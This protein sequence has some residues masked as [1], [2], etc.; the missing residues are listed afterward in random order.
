MDQTVTKSGKV[1]WTLQIVLALLFLFA[2]G[3]KLVMSAT[4][5][6]AQAPLPALFLRFIGVCELLGGLG[7]VL[8]WALNIRPEL[9]PLAAAGLIVIMVGA[10]VVS[11]LWA[12][13]A[14]AIVPLVV[15]V[16]LACVAWGRREQ[17]RRG[18]FASR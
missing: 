12:S 17:L 13:A 16:L 15:G 11:V 3:T 14:T 10:V 9:T 4:D 7:L 6:T 8:P 18:S 2:G 1:L 5:L